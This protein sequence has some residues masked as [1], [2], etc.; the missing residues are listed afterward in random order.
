MKSIFTIMLLISSIYR[1]NSDVIVKH[2]IGSTTESSLSCK[3]NDYEQLIKPAHLCI[4]ASS[5]MRKLVQKHTDLET[6]LD[7]DGV[8]ATLIEDPVYEFH[9]D[10]LRLEGKEN[11]RQFYL[12]HFYS[13][14]PLIKSHVFINANWDDHSARLE[15]DLYLKPPYNPD[16]PYRI[17]VTL[18]EKD[19]LL[20]GESFYVEN[21]LA[22]IMAGPSFSMFK[23]F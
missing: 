2:E 6:K 18:T 17:I 5:E 12:D 15:F 13:F 16:R 14:F 10:Q 19:S 8:L 3:R 4:E 9:P 23:K 11:V 21:E 7:L 1:T 22:Q 20:I